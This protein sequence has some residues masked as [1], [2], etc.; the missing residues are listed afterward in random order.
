MR[1]GSKTRRIARIGL[2]FALALILQYLES[3]VPVPFPAAPGIKLG[4]SNVVTMFCLFS[5]G[6]PDAF[7]IAVLKGGF[8]ILTRG[9]AAGAL[10]LAGGLFSV[11]VML[12]LTKTGQSRGLTGVAGAVSHNMG[13]L[14][15]ECIIM[16][17]SAALYYAPLLIISGVVMGT[18]TVYAYKAAEPYL[19]RVRGGT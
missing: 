15:A 2:L 9:P 6:T 14:A 16:R 11:A 17:S 12:V 13:Q 18:V 3:L 5:V 8:A 1:N 19:E 4:L 7:L 10:S